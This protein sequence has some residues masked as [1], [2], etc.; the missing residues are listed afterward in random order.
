MQKTKRIPVGIF[1]FVSLLTFVPYVYSASKY[2]VNTLRANLLS[3]YNRHVRPVT[4][5][6]DAI[7]VSV[8]LRM[9]ALQEFDEV[10]EKF[11]FLGV[12]I[13]KWRD[14]NFVWDS[15]NYSGINILVM[16][17]KE[18]W[19]PEIILTNPSEKIDSFGNDWQLIRY[20]ADGYALYVPGTLIKATCSINAYYFPF[21]VQ[22]CN[23]E[24]F[25][26]GYSYQEVSLSVDNGFIDTNEMAEHGSWTVIKTHAKP[27]SA[28]FASKVNFIIWFERKPEYVIVNIIL[29][30]LCL[31]LLN[32]LVF[33]LPPESGE[34]VSYS[35]TVLLS[36]A[37][38][39]TI[40]SDTLPKT[41]EPLPII[42]YLMM[43]SLT[44]SS[45]I[46]IA[47][48]LNLRLYHK[49]NNESV[50]DW[51]ACICQ[52]LKNCCTRRR[53]KDSKQQTATEERNST[54]LKSLILGSTNKV[55]VLHVEPQLQ[56]MAATLS[57]T[58][59]ISW[60]DVSMLIDYV[61]LVISASLTIM[62][63]SVFMIVTKAA[64]E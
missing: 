15:A 12:F 2:D 27:S 19:K 30:V 55:E 9:L 54:S 4:N 7:N 39:M 33:L 6:T 52:R 63:F 34:R 42:S 32:V 40:V 22:K 31:C 48:A 61:L 8:G 57:C 26:L 10:R 64:S 49:K 17:Y 47:T 51:L 43:I 25:A 37:V 60:Q 21:D 1:V 20:T 18:V 38:F 53:R 56:E 36:I 46:T 44:E 41:S 29:P 24:V 62:C 50:P 59:P 35:I 13:I 5:Q 14:D 23:V 28:D 58:S 45:V 11:S 3:G 16:G